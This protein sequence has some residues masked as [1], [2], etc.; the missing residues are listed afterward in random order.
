MLLSSSPARVDRRALRGL[1][2]RQ[3]LLGAPAQQAQQVLEEIR[4]RQ[5]SQAPAAPKD[6]LETQET[7][8]LRVTGGPLGTWVH[9]AQSALKVWLVQRALPALLET[10][11]AEAPLVTAA[12]QEQRDPRASGGLTAPED[13]RVLQDL[14][15]LLALRAQQAQRE[16]RETRE[17]LAL[18]V[19]RESAAYLEALGPLELLAPQDHK[20]VQ[21][22][23]DRLA[24]VAH[25][26]SPVVTA[27]KVPRA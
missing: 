14:K 7:E 24:T 9:V 25:R 12:P 18:E 26:D 13:L 3:G 16:H 22:A 4:V 5:D 6:E 19:A 1:K 27:L 17:H 2:D 8:V 23:L 15:D 11:E 21:E 20:G 10:P